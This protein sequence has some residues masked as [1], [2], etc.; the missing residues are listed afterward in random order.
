M[1]IE[2]MCMRGVWGPVGFVRLEV[3]QSW[4]VASL[5]LS[6][7]G[8]PPLSSSPNRP[9]RR[10]ALEPVAPLE[11]S[12]NRWVPS[13]AQREGAIDVDTPEV[14]AWKV[15]SL[16]NK[17]TTENFY[18]I[19]DQIIA[20]A[21]KSENEKDGRTLIQVIRLVYEKAIDDADRSEMYARLC[22]KMMETIS[23]K[24]QSD[25]IKSTDGKP[26]T[27]GQ[28][29]RKYLLSRCQD[30]FER[31]WVVKG[32]TARTATKASDDEAIKAANEGELY[33]EDY[34][35]QK[36]KR[37]GLGLIKFIGE[38][39]KLQMLSE[40]I[41]HKCI[42][43]LLGN[44]E[45][46]EEENIENLCQ[47]LRTAGQF[48][49]VPMTRVH[50]TL[51]FQ[52]MRELCKSPNVRPRI[53]FMLQDVIELRDRKWQPRGA[54][55]ATTTFA[56]VHEV[57]CIRRLPPS[58]APSQKPSTNVDKPEA[59]PQRKK[60]QLLPR[61][62]PARGE[63]P[64]PSSA[65]KPEAAP[66]AQ[67]SEKDAQKKIDEDVKEFFAVRS[68]EEAD[69]Y[70]TALTEEHRFRL[71]AKLV[72]SALESKEA[73]ARLVADFFSRPASQHECSPDAFEAGFMLTAKLLEDIII[74]T[75][76]AFDHMAIML[77][78]AGI[79]KDE[80]RMK[81]IAEVMKGVSLPRNNV[82]SVRQGSSLN[83]GSIDDAS[84]PVSS[85]HTATPVVRHR[86]F[87]TFG[88]LTVTTTTTSNIINGK[89]PVSGLSASPSKPSSRPAATALSIS[90]PTSAPASLTAVP[91][92]TTSPTA[93]ASGS[94]STLSTSLAATTSSST[95]S[96]STKS[97]FDVAE[98]FAGPQSRSMSGPGG[99]PMPSTS[100]APGGHSPNTTF[101]LAAPRSPKIA[102]KGEDGMGIE[103]ESSKKPSPQPPAVSISP[104]SLI[105]SL[106]STSVRTESEWAKWKREKEAKRQR[107]KETEAETRKQCDIV[108][109]PTQET[110]EVEEDEAMENGEIFESH[111][112]GASNNARCQEESLRID[113]FEF[114]RRR[115]G[116]LDMK[117]STVGLAQQSRG[118]CQ[119]A[120]A[121]EPVA[122]EISATRWRPSGAQCKGAAG[123]DTPEV[124]DRKVKSLLN[125][126]TVANLDS[127]SDQI[128]AWANK[129]ENEKDGRTLIQV[130][131]LVVEK[132]TDEADCSEIYARLCCKMMETIS[133]KVQSDG[134]KSTDGTP[135]AG[136]QLFR[137]YLLN[138]CQED[139]EC[140]WVAK[141]ATARAA[142]AKAS[143]DEPVK[144]AGKKKGDESEPYSD[145]YFTAQKAKRQ[146][147]GLIKFIGKLFKLEMLTECI[148]H[149][150]VKK[151]L[152][153][154]HP[155]E[156]EIESLCQLLKAVGQLLD[157]PKA[158][159]H[160][161]VYFQRMRELCKSP[162]IS[163]R[164]QLILQD[165]IEL[166]DWKWQPHNAV[167]V[168]TTLA[169]T[170]DSK[171]P[172]EQPSLMSESPRPVSVGDDP[173]SLLSRPTFTRNPSQ[174]GS[175]G[176]PMGGCRLCSTCGEKREVGAT[177]VVTSSMPVTV[178]L[179]VDDLV[180]VRQGRSAPEV[181]TAQPPPVPAPTNTYMPVEP[182]LLSAVQQANLGPRL[183]LFEF[184]AKYELS[185]ELQIKLRLN[186]FISSHTLRF[187]SLEDVNA[188]GL[189]RGEIAQLRDAI[190]RWCGV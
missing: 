56:S 62:I 102:I 124:V 160:M 111:V 48:L 61:T 69:A 58:R 185:D 60:L 83:F 21:N 40:R 122:P 78:G 3:A 41:M 57:V 180:H 107:Q 158:R 123:V 182:M 113:T 67:M 140:N 17:L 54:V 128:V 82:R 38:L 68:L 126:L 167:V 36:A 131:R 77:E 26:I 156:E 155:E 161:D 117:A 173:A 132:A 145:E 115:P 114:A 71:V 108:E 112:K 104:P 154:D 162:N 177:D 133:P 118:F 103:L 188:I 89:T 91:S 97:A 98:L 5:R 94:N 4:V 79:D 16:L 30:D 32:A 189:L 53:R 151:L 25:G 153:M 178:N 137:K 147:L 190:S 150:S 116:P 135:I 23:P 184:C 99:P 6:L 35:V 129:S 142:A 46:P 106:R 55:N 43:K 18:T 176:Q 73:D 186:G 76:R 109:C 66:A 121:F 39:F 13:S 7:G 47:L 74:D 84:V 144:A 24:V 1:S 80:E 8:L 92:A 127:I 120:P 65:E 33:N 157:V 138:R 139:F 169:D 165:V 34:V 70:F 63:A 93:P 12:A 143:N 75:P 187:T 81:R 2:D 95:N 44:M 86:S 170:T 134:V 141:E 85:S 51:Y 130:I 119:L 29:F 72:S 96:A 90:S 174:G 172:C 105:T 27:G 22:S 164:M 183:S 19:S 168:P 52:K 9:S 166:R 179:N 146:S 45:N 110:L 11:M 37:Q 148:I 88:S 10:P 42:K 31:G 14:V 20:W 64:S 49:D 87:K 149:E 125:K 171:L 15:K 28:L 175:S 100:T 159:A 50:M 152:N 181:P 136:G 59:T 163:P 101:F